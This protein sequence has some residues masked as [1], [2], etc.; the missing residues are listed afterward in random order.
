MATGSKRSLRQH[1]LDQVRWVSLR[2]RAGLSAFARHTVRRTGRLPKVR[3][4]Y[5]PPPPR[6]R[7]RIATQQ[8]DFPQPQL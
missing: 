4:T 5:D 7:R 1:Y 2:P 6:S 3:T 8:N